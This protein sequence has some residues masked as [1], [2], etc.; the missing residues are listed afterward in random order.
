MNVLGIETATQTGGIAIANE[1][2]LLSEY[3]L[4]VGATHSGRLL[5]AL[6]YVLKNSGLSLHEIDVLAVSLGPGSFTGLRIGICTAKGLALAAG[7]PIT[8][9]YTLDALVDVYRGTDAIVCPMLDA[10][11]KE[12]YTAAYRTSRIGELQVLQPPRAVAPERFLKSLH[13]DSVLFLGEGSV[14]YRALIE[15]ALGSRAVFAPAHLNQP[16]AAAIALL[17]LSQAKKG[18]F[19]SASSLTPLYVRPSDAEMTRENSAEML[20]RRSLLISS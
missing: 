19:L 9:I 8:G 4:C 7:K 2:G 12:V 6:D 10:R 1:K 17:G 20:K 5:P 11:K 15:Q 14:L 16:R 3:S 18:N 13:E